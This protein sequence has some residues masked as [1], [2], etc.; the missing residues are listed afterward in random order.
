MFLENLKVELLNEEQNKMPK[1]VQKLL[2]H[3]VYS[4]PF[5]YKLFGRGHTVWI[6]EPSIQTAGVTIKL[7]K[8][9]FYYSPKFMDSLSEG[10]LNFLLQHELYHITR[11]HSGAGGRGQRLTK[12]NKSLHHLAN[13][14]MDSIIN[15]D[16]IADGG[17]GGRSMKMI[18]GGWVLNKAPSDVKTSVIEKEFQNDEKDVYK[19]GRSL[20]KVYKWMVERRD[21]QKQK[22]PEEG[23]EGE[24]GEGGEGEGGD[25]S[26]LPSDGSIVKNRKT[27]QYGQV[28]KIGSNGKAEVRVI[29]KDE[30]KALARNK[31]AFAIPD[32]ETKAITNKRTIA[33]VSS[34]VKQHLE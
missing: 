33:S 34:K 19:D 25:D 3:F 17:F 16:L 31:N 5:V 10:E 11:S 24:G 26:W 27:G 12:G 1:K 13:I 8:I 14:A 23:E 2:A 6:P 32:K 18:E 22:E 15:E 21:N 7:G 28:K 30:A 29:T 9:Y 20:E 4:E